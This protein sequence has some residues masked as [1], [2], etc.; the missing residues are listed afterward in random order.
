MFL[1]PPVTSW[2]CRHSGV[3]PYGVVD[4]GVGV[5]DVHHVGTDL[6]VR[7]QVERDDALD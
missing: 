4:P 7:A 6:V 5:R 2:P 3:V 1:I